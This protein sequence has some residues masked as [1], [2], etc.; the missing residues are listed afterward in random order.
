MGYHNETCGVS[1]QQEALWAG[2]SRPEREGR[3]YDRRQTLGSFEPRHFR[4]ST[5][6]S[7]LSIELV[8]T[9]RNF[10]SHSLYSYAVTN[11]RS[12]CMVTP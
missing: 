1:V 5:D 7:G 8:H 6:L 11:S 2:L 12:F 10:L 9:K 3:E 4:H